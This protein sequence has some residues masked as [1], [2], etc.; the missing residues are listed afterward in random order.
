MVLQRQGKAGKYFESSLP[1][2]VLTDD[3]LE[4]AFENT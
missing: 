3:L 4:L 2:S 1:G